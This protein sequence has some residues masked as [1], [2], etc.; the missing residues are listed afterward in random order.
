MSTQ[1]P[2]LNPPA[3]TPAELAD[4]RRFRVFRYKRGDTGERFDKFEVPVG[5]HTTVLDALRWIQLHRDPS[6]TLR[7]SCLHASCG[8]CGMLVDGREELACVCSVNDH[9]AEIT[10]E[11]SAPA[12]DEVNRRSPHGLCRRDCCDRVAWALRR[13]QAPPAT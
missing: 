9:G 8:T 11:G 6:L 1:Q 3:D 13:I 5:A 4:T 10:V 7:H 2:S 12:L